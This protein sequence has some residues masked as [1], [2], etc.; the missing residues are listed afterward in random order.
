MLLFFLYYYRLYGY[1]LNYSCGQSAPISCGKPILRTVVPSLCHIHLQKA[2]RS[3]SQALRRAGIN[4]SSGRPAQ[5][6]ST[7][8]AEFVCGIQAQRTEAMNSSAID[9]VNQMDEDI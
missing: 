4:I 3:V 5:T 8:I 6:V 2:Q 7:L 9:V 1:C